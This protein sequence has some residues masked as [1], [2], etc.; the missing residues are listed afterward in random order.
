MRSI[1][2]LWVKASPGDAPYRV[3]HRHAM[4]IEQMDGA[5][6]DKTNTGRWSNRATGAFRIHRGA[7]RWRSRVGQG[8]A[9][10]RSGTP[11][12][13]ESPLAMVLS[14]SS[15]CSCWSF[16]ICMS[17]AK[18]WRG[19]LVHRRFSWAEWKRANIVRFLVI[20]TIHVGLDFCMRRRRRRH[21]VRLFRYSKKP[22]PLRRGLC[23][24]HLGR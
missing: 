12:C 18:A 16:I 13:C 17:L 3:Q 15:T 1:S 8:S 22:T 2:P 23:R 20:D 4:L 21:E 11:W 6:L 7:F 24:H 10:P 9:R 5:V 14:L 19:F